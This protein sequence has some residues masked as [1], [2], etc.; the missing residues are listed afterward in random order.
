MAFVRA[1]K[2]I[3]PRAFV[4]EEV[5]GLRSARLKHV[6]I[7]ERGARIL[8]PEEKKGSDFKVVVDMLRSTGYKL[9]YDVLNAADFGSPQSRNR[10]IFIGLREGLP[11]LPDKTHSNRLQ[12]HLDGRALQ[13]WN[14]FWECTA[15]LQATEMEFTELSP[16]RK[17]YMLFVPPGGHWRHLP[18]EAIK[19]AMGGAYRS[20][21]GKMGYFRRLTWVEPSPTVVTSPVQKGTMFCHPE[22]PRPLSIEEYKRIQGFPDDWAIVGNTSTKYRLI[23]GAV[24]VHLSYAIATKVAELLGGS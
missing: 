7:A 10:I 11:K 19:E 21:G 15:D 3:R 16:K 13:P 24:P 23:G 14:T 22:A 20:G 5:T 8:R 18:K 1:I 2:E 4:M 9:V 17:K 6:P 12:T